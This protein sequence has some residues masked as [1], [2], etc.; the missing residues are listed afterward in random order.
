MFW[1]RRFMRRGRRKLLYFF[2]WVCVL[3]FISFCGQVVYAAQPN[4]NQV[5]TN[6]TNQTNSNVSS[7]TTTPIGIWDD[8]WDIIKL[9]GG[10][11][12]GTL[13]ALITIYKFVLEKDYDIEGVE[14]DLINKKP[15]QNTEY[16]EFLCGEITI[17]DRTI[18]QIT[19]PNPYYLDIVVKVSVPDGRK[20]LKNIIVK[21]LVIDMNGY[22]LVCVPKNKGTGGLKKC[23]F[24]KQKKTCRILLKWPTIKDK[25]DRIALNPTMTFRSPDYVDMYM[26]WYPQIILSP[27]VGFLFPKKL[28]IEYEKIKHEKGSPRI[29]IKSKGIFEGRKNNG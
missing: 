19:D 6:Q 10:S 16:T 17:D 13:T 14:V 15:L 11:L 18:E 22:K 7:G 9:V 12:L 20:P 2:V 26:V 8:V 29:G 3:F 28:T 24:N 23:T 1:E 4:A 27:I 5:Q 21:K 25:N